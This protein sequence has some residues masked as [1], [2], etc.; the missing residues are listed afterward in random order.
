MRNDQPMGQP[1]EL[2]TGDQR[3]VMPPLW[4]TQGVI[5]IQQDYPLPATVLGIIP[6]IVVGDTK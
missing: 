3:M 1:I 2:E 6:E 4:Q 5:C